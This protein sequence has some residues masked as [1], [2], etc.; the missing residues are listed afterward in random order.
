MAEARNLY[1]VGCGSSYHASLMG[2]VYAAYL[3]GRPAIP[4][5]APQFVAQYGP[6]LG[7]NDVAVFVSQSGETKDILTAE[8]VA[9]Q[10]GVT[11]LGLVNV[12][13]STLCRVT[14]HHLPL[15]CG[16]EVS[17]PATK[18]FTNQSLAFL[19][20][21]LKMSNLPTANLDRL[22]DLLQ[23][24]LETVEPPI[25][26]LA[27][28]LVSWNEFYCLGYGA[29]YPVALEG[30]LKIKE[31][32]YAHCE[33]MLST[34]FKHGP[35]SAVS[36]DYPVIF[37]AA[38]QDVAVMVSGI[39]EVTTRYGRAIV[40]GEIDPRLQANATDLITL[41][42]AGPLLNPLLAALPMQLLAYHLSLAH[43]QDPDS[44][45]N[46]SKTLMVD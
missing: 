29:T 8:E 21:A 23:Q 36:P 25:K 12:P 43:L 20:L 2:A 5:P 34:E 38:P 35:L 15:A 28:E 11:T 26:T 19:Y 24:T 1:L 30:A 46:L 44:P 31:I 17:V 16:Y 32:S 4:V 6:A 33:G 41:P 40:F 22:P 42:Q 13:G 37:I 27:A 7:T 39:N 18:S 45:R 10:K 14:E 3:A 9:R